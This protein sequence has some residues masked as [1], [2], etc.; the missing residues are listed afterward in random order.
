MFPPFKDEQTA[1]EDHS[2]SAQ[3]ALARRTVLEALVASE[4]ANTLSGIALR[5]V[6]DDADTNDTLAIVDA[7]QGRLYENANR[8]FDLKMMVDVLISSIPITKAAH[9]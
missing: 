8:V 3:I 7:L 1:F 2:L 4:H 9:A 5:S 6:R